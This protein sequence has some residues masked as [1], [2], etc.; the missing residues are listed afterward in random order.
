MITMSTVRV[1][2]QVLR[3]FRE[4]VLQKHGRLHGA[5]LR[6]VDL[7]MRERVSRLRFEIERMS[8]GLRQKD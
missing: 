3:E 7:A 1:D 4:L 8:E 2:D 5:M 6:E